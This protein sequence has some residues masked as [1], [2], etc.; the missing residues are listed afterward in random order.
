MSEAIKKLQE[1]I[2]ADKETLGLLPKNNIKN[3][4]KSLEKIS[5]IKAK[6]TEVYEEIIEE[7]QERHSKINEA[8]ENQ[9]IGNIEDEI[10]RIED[11]ITINNMKT[12]Y[13]RMELDRLVFSINGFYKK[14]LNEVNQDIYTVLKKFESVGIP[15][16]AKDFDYSEYAHEYMKVFIEEVKKGNVYTD[17]I[18]E[19]FEKLYIKCSEVIMHISLNIRS[20]YHK[21]EK[22][23]DKF[24]ALKKVQ[25]LEE[26][27]TTEEQIADKCEAMK[28][29]VNSLKD[30]DERTILNRFMSGELIAN[31]YK[32]ENISALINKLQTTGQKDDAEFY[33]NVR[34]LSNNLK[35]YQI[36][37][38]FKF[39][40]SDIITMYKKNEKEKENKEKSKKTQYEETIE[41]IAKAEKKLSQLN[42]NLSKNNKAL[43]FVKKKETGEAEILERNN[44]ILA[45]KELYRKLDDYMIDRAIKAKIRSTT[46]ILE[47]LEF[48]TS[49]Y[50]FISRK[51][52]KQYPDITEDE[53]NKMVIRLK[54]A[55]K[56]PN[57]SVINNM[58]ITE[59]KDMTIIIKD[60]YK[61][62]GLNVNKEDFEEG[63]VESLINLTKTLTIY[64]NIKAS[65]LTIDQIEF[66]CKTKEILKNKVQN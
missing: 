32:K 56:Q 40:V 17:R 38:E 26:M 61:L 41:E 37:A 48:A 47:T 59:I 10:Q 43:F 18:K 29:R 64:N 39:L 33:A 53:I 28:A 57:F 11:N 5:E 51:I 20:L 14:K 9:E 52:I 21:N 1:R 23:I 63:N 42:A 6:Y 19:T 44:Q 30:K 49:Y 13:E 22:N 31:D 54:Q 25:T 7:M 35:E 3:I 2:E 45:I 4:T 66:M 24:Y 58:N 8:E 62:L 12:S 15:L 50:N 27:E 65:K 46:T 34:K 60:K 55:I 16:T 36:Y